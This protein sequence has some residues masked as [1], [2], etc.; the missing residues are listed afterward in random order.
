MKPEASERNFTPNSIPLGS[1][2]WGALTELLQI[3][4]GHGLWTTLTPTWAPG[5]SRLPLSSTARALI[6]VLPMDVGVQE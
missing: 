2:S 6:V 4:Q 5:L 1:R 3:E